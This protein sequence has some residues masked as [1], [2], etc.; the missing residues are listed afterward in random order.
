M[1]CQPWCIISAASLGVGACTSCQDVATVP[2]GDAGLADAG[3][4]APGDTKGDV[5][6]CK[7]ALPPMKFVTISRGAFVMGSP[8]G[9]PGRGK[10]SETQVQV[11]LTHDIEM[12]ATEITQSQWQ[13][14]CLF[15]PSDGATGTG[16]RS[17]VGPDFPV[18]TVTYWD[19]LSYAN[20][21]SAFAGLS[22]CYKLLGCSGAI[23]QRRNCVGV[24]PVEKSFYDCPG[25]RLPT[26][27]EFEY[28]NRAGTTTATYAGEVL[29]QPDAGVITYPDPSIDTIGWC[30]ATGG[31]TTHAVGKLVPN[32]WGIYD[33]IG[34]AGEWVDGNFN[35]LGYGP[36]PLTDPF[37][38]IG[39]IKNDAGFEGLGGI[40]RGGASSSF[41]RQ[42][43]SA[44]QSEVPRTDGTS[45]NV[46]FRLVRTLK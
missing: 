39:S 4:D 13:A 21:L 34:N 20:E 35:G 26:N 22:Q 30:G 19:A 43:R 25:Y 37:G 44:E 12:T 5:G 45:N 29:D 7:P 36:G 32:V 15:D 33:M 3:A 23:G 31:S 17:G 27:A 10:H 14:L 11:T 6:A 24:E 38:S 2:A 28:A 41:N 42:C 9:E 18:G 1:R 16:Q 40:L 8:T 46:G